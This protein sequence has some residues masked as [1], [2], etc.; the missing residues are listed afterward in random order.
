[1]TQD[2]IGVMLNL[3]ATLSE[4]EVFMTQLSTMID[5]GMDIPCIG[6]ASFPMREKLYKQVRDL[7]LGYKRMDSPIKPFVGDIPDVPNLL[8]A[9][10]NVWWSEGDSK[11]VGNI[12]F[13]SN[14]GL[15]ADVICPDG[16]RMC[17]ATKILHYDGK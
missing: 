1:M 11:L 9:G 4:Y 3:R 15:T 5:R 8:R 14:D 16:T 12:Q 2:E 7:V 17:V 13:I 6:T 10:D